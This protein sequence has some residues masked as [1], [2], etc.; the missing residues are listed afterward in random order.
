M[1]RSDIN[2]GIETNVSIWILH[3]FKKSSQNQTLSSVLCCVWPSLGT[4]L[5]MFM[6]LPVAGDAAAFDEEWRRGVGRYAPPGSRA[7]D[8]GRDRRA[9]AGQQLAL[10][11]PTNSASPPA[12][13]HE[14]P[15]H[16]HHQR[17]NS[18]PRYDWWKVRPSQSAPTRLYSFL[19]LTVLAFDYDWLTVLTLN[20]SWLY[21]NVWKSWTL[22][23]LKQYPWVCQPL[24][25]LL[26]A[27]STGS[28]EKKENIWF[29]MAAAL[30]FGVTPRKM[31]LKECLCVPYCMS[32]LAVSSLFVLWW[33]KS[34]ISFP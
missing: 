28:R 24:T 26:E 21:P 6:C 14:S 18:R 2:M 16:H 13:R 34:T 19:K 33:T 5:L 20:T 23:D 29:N 10:T 8:Y 17:P 1:K 32:A 31:K 15:R 25:L 30:L 9:G 7:I 4:S 11:A 3:M 27:M 12:P 22:K